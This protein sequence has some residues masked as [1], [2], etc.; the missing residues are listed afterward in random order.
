MAE[1]FG[2][3][4]TRK[5]DK[6]SGDSFTVPTPDDGSTEVAGGGFFSSALNTGGNEKIEKSHNNQNAIVLLK[7]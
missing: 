5:Q 2:F 4:I 6:D 7:I 1:L 3:S